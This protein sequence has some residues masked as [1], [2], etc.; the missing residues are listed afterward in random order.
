M[1]PEKEVAKNKIINITGVCIII[2]CIYK[3]NVK[4]HVMQINW[5]KVTKTNY[6]FLLQAVTIITP[7]KIIKNNNIPG[8]LKSNINISSQFKST[9]TTQ[10]KWHLW[11]TKLSTQKCMW[12]QEH[13]WLYSTA[14]TQVTCIQFNCLV[15]VR[16]LGTTLWTPGE[17][18]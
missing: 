7:T 1:E 9:L 16:D 18:S 17:F 15:Q 6:I 12:L 5:I 4:L 2:V 14:Y 3:A 13:L 10:Q 8:N 11:S